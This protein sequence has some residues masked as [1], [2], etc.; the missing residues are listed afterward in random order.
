M[1]VLYQSDSMLTLNSGVVIDILDLA[2]KAKMSP[3]RW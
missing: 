3:L 2:A 1:T